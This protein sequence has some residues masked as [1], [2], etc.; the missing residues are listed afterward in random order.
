MVSL[1]EMHHS[2]S[3]VC[4]S[5]SSF[6]CCVCVYTRARACMCVHVIPQGQGWEKMPRF[7]Y[8]LTSVHC[9]LKGQGGRCTDRCI[10]AEY[11]SFL[12]F[13]SRNMQG[14]HIFTLHKHTHAVLEG[15]GRRRCRLHHHTA[16]LRYRHLQPVGQGL[17]LSGHQCAYH[18]WYHAYSD[19]RRLR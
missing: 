10:I 2:D 13:S 9:R 7:F 17:P 6:S 14:I 5:V 3:C 12:T 1:P 11:T 19:I 16:F 8:L 4:M 15:Q 18:P